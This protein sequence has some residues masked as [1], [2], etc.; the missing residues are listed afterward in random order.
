VKPINL[1]TGL[2]R[3]RVSR[4]GTPNGLV[5]GQTLAGFLSVDDSRF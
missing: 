4:Q 3:G 2:K 1:L 5:E